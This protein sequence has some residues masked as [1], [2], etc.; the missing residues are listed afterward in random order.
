M[1]GVLSGC[2]HVC[3][4]NSNFQFDT[5]F[6][7]IITCLGVVKLYQARHPDIAANAHIVYTGFAVIIFIAMIGVVYSSFAFWT[8]FAIIHVFGCLYLSSQIYYM[9][10]V[11]FDAGMFARVFV[12]LRYDCCSCPVYKVKLQKVSVSILILSKGRNLDAIE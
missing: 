3:P 2:Y 8:T 6:M 10:R 9:G 4:N 1:E 7:Y 12:L 5:S 11:K